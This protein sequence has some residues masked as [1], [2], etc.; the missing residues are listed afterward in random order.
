MPK[1]NP[2][3]E[4]VLNFIREFSAENG[5]APSIRAIYAV[6]GVGT[7]AC[8]NSPMQIVHQQ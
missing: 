4:Q 2:R 1:T 6:A 3:E 5:D 7:P 8:V